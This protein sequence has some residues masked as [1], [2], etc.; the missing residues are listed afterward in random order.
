MS[1]QPVVQYLC[2]NLGVDRYAVEILRVREIRGWEPARV[3]PD[4]PQHMLGV[5]DFREMM[6]PVFDLRLRFNVQPVVYEPTTVIIVF[7]SAMKNEPLLAV[8]VDGVSDVLDVEQAMRCEV[9]DMGHHIDTRFMDG[10]VKID[11]EVVVLLNTEYFLNPDELMR[12]EMVVE[13]EM[14]EG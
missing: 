9:P 7:A 8:V 12:L 6:V 1:D 3:I 5:I 4:M 10:M 13:A 2:F 11:G 14:G